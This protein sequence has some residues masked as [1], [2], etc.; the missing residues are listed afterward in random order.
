TGTKNGRPVRFSGIARDC[1]DRKRAEEMLRVS[2]EKYRALVETTS[3]W[4]WETDR[5]GA[6][7]YSSPRVS[8]LLGYSPDEIVGKHP[9]E[10]M[11]PA[12]AKRLAPVVQR[13]F[14]TAAPFLNLQNWNVRR[15]GGTVLLETSGVPILD[16][17]G[18]L[19]GFRG[20]DRDVTERHER[21]AALRASEARYRDLV[22]LSPEAVFVNREDQI[23]LLNTAALRLF[24]ASR[25]EELL[26]KPPFEVFHPDY[27]QAI[28]E[29]VQ[30]LLSGESVPLLEER[31]VRLDGT[32][33][34]VEV[35]ASAFADREGRSIQV[36]LRDITERK[37]TQRELQTA[38]L[39]LL[40][41]NEKLQSVTE[42]L[43]LSNE[44]LERRV[45]NQTT[46][47]RQTNQI[48]RMVSECNQALVR[49][50]DEHRLMEE[51]CRVIIDVGGYRMAWVGFA[52]PDEAKS[53]RPVA[54]VGVENGYLDKIRISWADDP[55]GQGPTGTSIRTKTVC[56]GTDFLTQS[57]LAPWKA[58]ALERGFRSSIALPL[59]TEGRAF[60]AL[61][62]Y[63]AETDSFNPNQV[64]LLKGLAEDMAFGITAL[65][66]HVE[67]DRVRKEL[68]QKATQLQTLTAELVQAE[69]RERRRLAQILHDSL[70]QLLVG[71]RY[72]LELL[73][74][75]SSAPS[76]QE[77]ISRIDGFIADCIQTSRS[78]TAELSPP[79]LYEAGLASALRWLGRWFQETHGLGVR[80]KASCELLEE[81]EEVRVTIFQAIRE[82]LFNVVKH[83][84]VNRAEVQVEM[85]K[86]GSLGITVSD[87]GAGFEPA[88]LR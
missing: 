49:I 65:R 5:N 43:R 74:K 80:V 7:T 16:Q 22:E 46:E 30:R 72:N 23:V 62:I 36:I 71:A 21:E 1:T 34:E 82:L 57:Q 17:R 69:A 39:Q 14:E 19:L 20:I 58:L 40:I 42:E 47:L 77:T 38:N 13:H 86:E 61:S 26:G 59:V 27:H 85:P 87:K 2:G 35:A 41:T 83:A 79:V 33:L 81:P 60:G 52:E 10:L 29:R 44:T 12:E 48:L 53:V 15:D 32:V 55:F 28:R 63:A 78:L 31:I 11:A 6:Y 76:A 4:I 3:D 25:P 37:R 84:Q 50:S 70:Q 68:E 9:L 73:R 51:I 8:H 75:Q 64:E 54:A 88:Q 18:N 24:G 67:R 56:L 45:A 66:A